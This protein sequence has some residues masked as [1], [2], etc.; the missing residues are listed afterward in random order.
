MAASVTNTFRTKSRYEPF[1]GGRV[2]I[3]GFACSLPYTLQ[4]ATGAN[5]RSIISK[6]SDTVS[7]LDF[8]ADR[9]GF[10]DSTNAITVAHLT[11]QTVYYPFGSY[12]INGNNINIPA[13]GILGD[14][15]G[16]T[17]LVVNDTSA[18]DIFVYTGQ[19]GGR[20]ED[21]TIYCNG[22]QKTTGAMVNVTSGGVGE[23]IY[24]RFHQVSFGNGPSTAFYY[25]TGI[26]FT[27]AS[28]WSV[29]A[30]IFENFTQSG[31][32]IENQ[33]N[34]DSGDSVISNCYLQHNGPQG[35]LT[36]SG[37]LQYSSG[38][39]KITGTKFNGGSYGYQLAATGTTS[40]LAISGCSFE[41][42]DIAGINLIQGATGVT[43][44]NI[45]IVGNQFATSG[46]RIPGPV[47]WLQNIDIVGN[48]IG[49]ATGIAIDYV[50][51]F[52]IGGNTFNGSYGVVLGTSG[53]DHNVNGQIGANNCTLAGVSYNVDGGVTVGAF[54][55]PTEIQRVN[56]QYGTGSINTTT[57][58][59]TS[60]IFQGTTTVVYPK[61]YNPYP[62]TSPADATITLTTSAGVGAGVSAYN[63]SQM[64]VYA[65][66]TT[67][68]AVPFAW[69]TRG[70]F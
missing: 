62:V 12:L 27:R 32:W 1:S 9:T 63:N 50:N 41:S 65:S 61:G 66:S 13:G 10:Y 8:G 47:S 43:F 4:N 48:V 67:N 38:G 64:V 59:G 22:T 28:Q 24:A 36:G 21:F 40:D 14:G 70:I 23:N 37:V 16:L 29:H 42:G 30:C 60:G 17:R 6:L 68:G 15:I 44:S 33:N 69:E 34:F 58:I 56:T 19:T 54:T 39:L 51:H 45:T 31:I 18:N 25:P 52:Y 3:N 26:H 20:F 7:V 46:I 5:T 55:G 2:D 53:T 49:A 11:N 35:Q 57:Q